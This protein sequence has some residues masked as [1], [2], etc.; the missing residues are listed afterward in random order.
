MK[1]TSKILERN[2]IIDKVHIFCITEWYIKHHHENHYGSSA[3]VCFPFEYTT[4]CCQFIP[5]Q[6]IYSQCAHAKVSVNLS[7][8]TE[9]CVLIA[10]P[11][12]LKYCV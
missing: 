7:G 10:I 12:H 9:E 6:R 3:T 2:E 11:I 1:H 8:C 5:V 4:D